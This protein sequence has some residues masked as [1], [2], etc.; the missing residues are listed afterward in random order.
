MSKE[1]LGKADP[2][3]EFNFK[4]HF[5]RYDGTTP[6]TYMATSTTMGY[7]TVHGVKTAAD[8]TVMEEDYAVS[9]TDAT[10]DF[11]LKHGESIVFTHLPYPSYYYRAQNGSNLGTDYRY[12]VLIT[13]EEVEGYK[14]K[15]QH[16]AK[17]FHLNPRALPGLRRTI[18]RAAWRR[19]SRAAE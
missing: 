11:T 8:G 9:K 7:D 15:S 13:E 10:V 19:K 14:L 18:A 12:R 2:N 3:Q 5:Y 4:L 17:L 16:V 6:F 1:V